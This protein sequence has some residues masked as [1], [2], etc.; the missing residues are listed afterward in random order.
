MPVD[1]PHAA[2]NVAH[3]WC[4]QSGKTRKEARSR[5]HCTQFVRCHGHTFSSLHIF[6]DAQR[7]SQ[8]T[9]EPGGKPCQNGGTRLA[10]RESI[11]V[12]IVPVSGFGKGDPDWESDGSGGRQWQMA[13][14]QMANVCR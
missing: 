11:G 6:E 4:A 1:L 14:W 5:I 10:R 2:P 13:T 12:M 7:Q 9:G 8:A 3:Q